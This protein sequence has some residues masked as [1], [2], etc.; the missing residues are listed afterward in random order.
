M[1]RLLLVLALWVG[2]TSAPSPS[3]EPPALFV[4]QQAGAFGFIDDRGQVVI[5][6]QY[7]QAANFYD[8]LALVQRD[9]LFGYINP[10]GEE[11][12]P[13]QFEDAWHFSEGLA[14]VFAEGRWGFINRTGRMVVE[15]QYDVVPRA[16]VSASADSTGPSLVRVP[17]GFQF[18]AE[19]DTLTQVFDQAWL[20]KEGLARVRS[21]GRWGYIDASGTLV[22]PPQ[23]I[24]AWDFERG[25]ALVE[26]D[27]G[28]GYIN[29]QGQFVWG[30]AR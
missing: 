3:T 14:P 28:R 10:A 7:E 24:Q 20:F 23:F 4:I 26:T 17:E 8:G 11:V 5:P 21:S 16:I 19:G 18:V 22:I 27:A 2:C 29:R 1:Y 6:P 15:P 25:L 13:P 30:P 9:G 12:I